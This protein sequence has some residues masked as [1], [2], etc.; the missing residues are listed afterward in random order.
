MARTSP[1]PN[2]AAKDS[3]TP[4]FASRMDTGAPSSAER[5]V[6]RTPGIPQGTMRSKYRSSVLTLRANPCQ[7]TQSLAWTP[8]E[9][10]F[11]A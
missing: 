3:T 6:M 4:A 10:T 9:A 7:V 11:L 2:T 5:L 1:N 8:I